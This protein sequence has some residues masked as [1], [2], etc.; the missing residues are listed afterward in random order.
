LFP[1]ERYFAPI[2]YYLVPITHYII[3]PRYYF[4]PTRKILCSYKKDIL[5]PT[6]YTGTSTHKYGWAKQVLWEFMSTPIQAPHH[7]Q[8]T[9]P[10]QKEI[11]KQKVSS[12][13]ICVCACVF[14]WDREREREREFAVCGVKLNAIVAFSVWSLYYVPYMSMFVLPPWLGWWS[15]VEI[16]QNLFNSATHTCRCPKSGAK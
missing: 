1:Q 16:S 7:R 12:I 11:R 3:P 15:R 2:T 8:E 4:V 14:V 9:N 13:Y 5:F 6:T 10:K